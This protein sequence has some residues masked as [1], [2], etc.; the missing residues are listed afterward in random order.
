M[1][2]LLDKK[3]V[4]VTGKGGVGKSAIAAGIALRA[5]RAG[6]RALL[7]EVDTDGGAGRLFGA[8][9]LAF[10]PREVA[11]GLWAANITRDEAMRAFVRRF[12]P[13][14]KI[15]DMILANRVA[16]I[17]FESAPSVM[18]AVIVDQIANLAAS[19]HP[20]WDML[21]VDL[22]A[23]GHALTFLNVPRSMVEMVRTGTLAGHMRR[24]ADALSDPDRSELVIVTL[25]EEM[26]VNETIE[27]WNRA[28]A[29]LQTPV[30]HIVV[31]GERAPDLRESDEAALV[32]AA[33]GAD[34][35]GRARVDRVRAGVQLG[36]YWL[37]EDARSIARLTETG[38]RVTRIPFLFRKR[39]DRDLVES[40]AN[41]LAEAM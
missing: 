11:P 31:N 2:P 6:R 21:V 29:D 1:R 28:R 40:I 23:S 20:A 16:Q 14:G 27:L 15:A 13:V 7:C 8:P 33:D 38:A 39:D 3:L 36:R 9:P 41:H 37:I 4:F 30:R 12:V 26:P 18:E 34:A 17:F 22:P 19:T 25:P 35:A 10:T 32:A 5:S 24:L